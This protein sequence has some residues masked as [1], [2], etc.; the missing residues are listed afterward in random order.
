M[1]DDYV[2]EYINEFRKQNN[3]YPKQDLINKYI[4]ILITEKIVQ[5]DTDS[6]IAEYKNEFK[7]LYY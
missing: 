2:S 3:K 5:E 7:N 6:L 1:Q 4:N